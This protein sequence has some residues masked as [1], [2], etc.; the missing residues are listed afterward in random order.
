MSSFI[1]RT[2]YTGPVQGV[3]LD[4]A[5]T[6]VDF[7]CMGPV[8]V[9]RES[10]HLFDIDISVSEVRQFMGLMKKDH[11]RHL[12]RLPAVS[13]RWRD[14]F[15]QLPDEADVEALYAE[16]E[17]MMVSSIARYSDPVPGLLETVDELRKSGIRIG[18]STGYT[19]P[20][21]EILIPAARRKGYSPD[22]IVCSTDT[23]AGRP[24]PW[25]CFQ[26]A[27]QLQIYPMESMVKIGDT[28]TDIEEGLNAGMWTI[29]L[30]KSGNSLGLSLDEIDRLDPEILKNRL[31]EIELSMRE[32]G[33]HYVAEGIWACLP[34]IRDINRRLYRGKQPLMAV[35]D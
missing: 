33:A 23:P 10:F 17:P 16:T 27:I 26:N 34:I 3:V 25:M 12:C 21:M 6:A 29:G 19:R 28:I 24:Y 8:E 1:R 31:S 22:A 14:K 32:A 18:S 30:T 11:I 35:A 7:G 5:G 4:W 20:M 13:A 2:A 15:G 9:F